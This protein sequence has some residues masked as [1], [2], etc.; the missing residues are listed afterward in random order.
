[1]GAAGRGR[2]RGQPAQG[3][4]ARLGRRQRADKEYGEVRELLVDEL[5]IDPGPRLARL[6]EAILR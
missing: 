2:T 6:Y 4:P 1:M 5:G 3:L